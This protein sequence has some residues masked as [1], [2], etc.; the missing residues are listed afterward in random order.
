MFDSF[1]SWSLVS[2][3]GLGIFHGAN[4]GMG[5]LFAVAIGMQHRSLKSVIVALGPIALGH[6]LAIGIVV[7]AVGLLGTVMPTE[8]LLIL[9]G[10][11]LLGFASY[12]IVTRF[13]HPTWVGMRV[14]NAELVV[15]SFLMAT[16]HGAG[17]MLVPIVLRIQGNAGASA[18]AGSHH[19]H[20]APAAFQS[21][22]AALTTVGVHTLAMIST[23]S[24]LAIVVY[25]LVGVSILRKVWINLDWVW[26]G[27]LGITGT[28]TL[29]MGAVQL[30]TA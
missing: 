3:I 26:A 15:W 14:S 28:V 30:I 18:A 2:L 23:A 9:S 4:P 16:A 19:A 20:H 1:F 21:V 27:A 22:G 13:R 24:I 25:S 6:A 7:S 11:I 5:W 8:H 17:L 10:M 29:I 12:K